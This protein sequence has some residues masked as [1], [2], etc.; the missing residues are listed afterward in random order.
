MAAGLLPKMICD[1]V[2][3]NPGHPGSF[4]CLAGECL[5]GAERCEE[6]L[7]HDLLSYSLIDRD[8]LGL[9]QPLEYHQM[10]P[11]LFLWVQLTFVKLFGFNEYSLRLFSFVAGIAAVFLFY[12]L[13][14]EEWF[15]VLKFNLAMTNTGNM[16]RFVIMKFI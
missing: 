9:L 15:L 10:A 13:A 16:V 7:L 14:K 3:E 1:F 4:G 5:F 6:G 11:S 2:A 8:Y 12:H